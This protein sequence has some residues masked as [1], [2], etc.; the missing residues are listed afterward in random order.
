MFVFSFLQTSNLYAGQKEVRKLSLDQIIKRVISH[1][2][3]VIAKRALI[4]AAKKEK[5]AEWGAHLP[6]INLTGE[7][8]KTRYP[9][10]VTPISGPGH[11]PHFSK[12][13]YLYNLDMEIPIY[14]GGRI[15]KRVRIAELETKI[16]ESLERETIHD[17]IANTKDTFYLILYLHALIKA[18][19]RAIDALRK[20]Y[21]DA[22]VRLKVQRIPPLDLLRIKT[23]LKTEEALLTSSK[24]YLIRAKQA[25]SVLMGD[26]PKTDFVIIGR[27]PEHP[28]IVSKNIDPSRFLSYRPDI[29]A[30]EQNVKK[31]FE[32][33]S[34]AW[35]E[36]LPSLHLFS[37]YGRKAGGGFHH[38]EDLWEI[39][40]RLRLNL[41][42]GGTIS[43]EV[44][45]ARAELFAAREELRQKRL[46]AEKEIKAAISKLIE[47]KAQIKR[48]RVAKKTA[49]E[50]YR[51][52]SL[53]Y[54]T[55]VGTVT[56]ML[57]SQ[58]AWLN[59]EADYLRALYSHQKAKIEYEYATG[60]IAMSYIK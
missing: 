55:G 31:A 54:R 48:Y 24:E 4:N 40:L 8:Y 37:S 18:Q 17:L 59:A 35:R 49:K 23:Q 21:K 5:R 20:E 13:M 26:P 22:L 16:R 6:Q 46:T 12:D 3:E 39:G 27:L 44:E 32:K 2:P 14:E 57:I 60:T 7:A 51:V 19:K 36:N 47:T 9:T 1:N 29:R 34:L 43:A 38:D 42:S 25:L 11:F 56:D 45:K 33:V 50:A 30:A 52:E 10:A 41:Y 53:K 58:A 28:F 15:S